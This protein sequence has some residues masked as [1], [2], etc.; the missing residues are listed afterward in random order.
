MSEKLY[1]GQVL[2]ANIGGVDVLFVVEFVE[3]IRDPAKLPRLRLSANREVPFVTT[4]FEADVT[5]LPEAGDG[6]WPGI[7]RPVEM[8]ATGGRG[9]PSSQKGPQQAARQPARATKAGVLRPGQVAHQFYGP[10][11]RPTDQR[12][13]RASARPAGSAR[14]GNLPTMTR[15]HQFY[16]GNA[17]YRKESRG[18]PTAACGQR[19]SSR[20]AS[21]ERQSTPPVYGGKRRTRGSYLQTRD[22]A[23]SRRMGGPPPPVVRQ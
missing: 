8:S 18:S 10:S 16:G 21:T 4:S 9:S 3:P 22:S 5:L 15:G 14:R 13:Q 12:H 23:Q 20:N 1:S 19:T 2:R 11:S 7:Q 17:E 6:I